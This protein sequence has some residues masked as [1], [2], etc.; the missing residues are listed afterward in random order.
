MTASATPKPL[1]LYLVTEDWAF[2]HHRRAMAHAARGSGF[3]VAV[4]CRVGAHG[5]RIEAEGFAVHPLGLARGSVNPLTEMASIAEITALY[6]RLKPALVHH[7]ALKPALYGAIAARIA[8][9]PAINA[10]AGLGFVFI[11]DRPLARM[12]RPLLQL[13][14]RGLLTSRR[15]RLL[16]QNRDDVELFTA[17]NIAPPDRIALIRGSGVD[18]DRYAQT[19]PPRT[20]PVTLAYVG[21]MIGD[22]GV[23]QLV[24]AMRLANA[25]GAAVRLLLVGKPD[26]QNPTS[27]PRTKLEAWDRRPDIEWRGEVEDVRQIWREA[28]IAI[29]A[30]RREGLP[31]SL[32]EAAAMG[33][34]L[35]ATDVPGCREVAIKGENAEL[36]PFGDVDALAAAIC[37]LAA[38]PDLRARY[39]AASRRIV[40]SD[41]SSQSVGAAVVA[42]YKELLGCNPDRRHRP[43]P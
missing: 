33:R 4:A 32:M 6:R 14:F 29:L 8:G 43:A 15:S 31:M 3:E 38:D 7:V 22:K 11:S 18:I 42:L 20:G 28:H 16:L 19:P 5:P 35:I 2:W 1:L 17:R 27:I 30:T 10:L 24:E 23:D 34:P 21:R 40:V 13:A 26:P 25:N 37:R 12:A 9:V 36:V 39:G 41:L